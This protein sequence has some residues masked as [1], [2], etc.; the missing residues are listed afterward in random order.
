MGGPSA[1]RPRI[2]KEALTKPG[3]IPQDGAAPSQPTTQQTTAS[4]PSAFRQAFNQLR[5]PFWKNVNDEAIR[6]LDA[7]VPAL[8][9]A[10]VARKGAV[11]GYRVLSADLGRDL[12]EDISI[13]SRGIKDFGVYD[14][15]DP[16]EGKRTP[17]IW[18]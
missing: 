14:M 1:G 4:A 10:A 17:S 13:T 16:R 3:L 5:D 12:E 2:T 7:W 8:F 18:F 15:G 11:G 6:N 9:P